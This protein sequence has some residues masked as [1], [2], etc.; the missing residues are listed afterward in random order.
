[1]QYKFVLAQF[2]QIGQ[3]RMAAWKLLYIERRLRVYF[4]PNKRRQMLAQVEVQGVEIYLLARSD[5]CCIFSCHILFFKSLCLCGFNHLH[6]LKIFLFSNF[7]ERF[8]YL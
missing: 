7:N 5:R 6:Y 2:D 4:A 1:S 8:G 3:I